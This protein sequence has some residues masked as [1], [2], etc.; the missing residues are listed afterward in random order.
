MAVTQQRLLTM[1]QVGDVGVARFNCRS[2]LDEGQVQGV[3][4]QLYA[5][6]KDSGLNK[7]VLDFSRVEALTSTLVGKLFGLHRR[8][9]QGGGKLVLCG[10]R[11]QLVEV[12]EV[13][14]IADLFRICETEQEALQE[15]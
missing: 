7:F 5:L 8:L 14:K 2:L 3:G 11:P 4:D 13:L 12:F 6:V 10:V 1:E 9:R 15:L